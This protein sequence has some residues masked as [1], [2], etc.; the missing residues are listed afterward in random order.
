M[1]KKLRLLP[2]G[3][4]FCFVFAPWAEEAG[5][6]DG[7]SG[8]AVVVFELELMKDDNRDDQPGKCGIRQC[9]RHRPVSSIGWNNVGSINWVS[10]NCLVN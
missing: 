4:F 3:L 9:Q 8:V 2:A 10:N 5:T 6:A 7:A 1:N